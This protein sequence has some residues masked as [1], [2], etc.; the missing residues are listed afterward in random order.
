[1]CDDTNLSDDHAAP[2]SIV[3]WIMM[4]MEAARS[5]EMLVSYCITTHWYNPEDSDLNLH[6]LENLVSQ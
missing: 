4:K 5:S 3:K 6:R 1:M 2:V